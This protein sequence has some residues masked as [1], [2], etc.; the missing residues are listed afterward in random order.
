MW[1]GLRLVLARCPKW[2][3]LRLVPARCPKWEELRLVPARRPKWEGLR[4]VPA[5]RPMIRSGLSADWCGVPEAALRDGSESRRRFRRKQ[6]R[7]RVP[8]GMGWVI[9]IPQ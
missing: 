6:E 1:E 4:L 8:C 7:E 9:R 2:E 5:W 3:G